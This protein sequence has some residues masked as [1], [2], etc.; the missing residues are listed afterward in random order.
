MKRNLKG[1]T[2]E[3][4]LQFSVLTQVWDSVCVC[5]CAH[6]CVWERMRQILQEN[7]LCKDKEGAHFRKPIYTYFTRTPKNTN[8]FLF[9]KRLFSK[10]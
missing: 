7:S 1:P 6:A 10:I 9:D 5:V 2:G 4:D 3:K 8:I